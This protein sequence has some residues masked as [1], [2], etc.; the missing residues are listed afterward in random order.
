MSPFKILKALTDC[1]QMGQQEFC[2]IVKYILKV[3]VWVH[4]GKLPSGDVYPD[5]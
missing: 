2:V 4:I 3:G 5:V 1:G